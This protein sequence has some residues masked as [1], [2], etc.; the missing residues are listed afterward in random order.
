[1]IHNCDTCGLAHEGA[2]IAAAEPETEAAVV[3]EDNGPNEHD[4]E[5]AKIEA[6]AQVKSDKIYAESRDNELVAE[7]ERLRG[8]LEGVKAALAAIQPPEPEPVPV[9]VP[10]PESAP[11]PPSVPPP[12]PSGEMSGKSKG[13][14]GGGWWD[15]YR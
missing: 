8:E 1:M 6:E 4:V 5:I 14:T 11:E 3:V 9:P 2:A 13:K 7:N 15:N 10:V 12:P